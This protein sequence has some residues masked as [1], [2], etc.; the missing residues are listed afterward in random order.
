MQ[1]SDTTTSTISIVLFYYFQ[2]Q[3]RQQ[4]QVD[5]N[6]PAH[7]AFAAAGPVGAREK[8]YTLPDLTNKYPNDRLHPD[9]AGHTVIANLVLKA[10]EEGTNNG[11]DIHIAEGHKVAI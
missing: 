7:S 8:F 3:K 6:D 10:I 5:L 4:L 9:G 1:V 2:K 11:A